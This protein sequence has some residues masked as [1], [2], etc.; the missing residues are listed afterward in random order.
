MGHRIRRQFGEAFVGSYSLDYRVQGE[1]PDGSLIVEYTL[2]NNTSNES[3]LHYVGYYDWLENFN[4]D[5]GAFSTVSQKIVWTERIPA[6][7]QSYE[8]AI[9]G[10]RRR[11]RGR[12]R[13]GG[14]A[15]IRAARGAR[16]RVGLVPRG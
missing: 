5:E 3:F 2:D 14:V 11:L 13:K 10:P 8:E 9:N 7:D 1:D 6:G 12:G 4:R 15:S 16:E